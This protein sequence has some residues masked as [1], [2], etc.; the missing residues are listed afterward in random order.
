M[1]A[2]TMWDVILFDLD[3]TI[4]DPK[5]GITKSV[6]YALSHFGF[7]VED[8]DSLAYFIGPPLC[9]SFQSSFGMTESQAME[10]LS[11]YRER[12]SSIGWAE[13]VPYDSIEYC[14]E[15]LKDAGKYLMIATSKAQEFAE[16]I[17]TH[18]NLA[19]YFDQICG[20]P[21]NE[22]GQT[23][24]DVIRTAL[25]RAGISSLSKVVMVGDRCQDILGGQEVGIKTVGVLYGY[26][27][28]LE[29]ESCNADYI[30]EDIEEL[31]GLLLL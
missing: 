3:G 10:A 14:L 2:K 19:K 9:D 31:T 20:T 21:M 7:S 26:G 16:K 29:H 30:V 25:G 28:R 5:E 1:L 4:T 17:L 18:F 12:Y 15:Q 11:I 24:A 27:D 13:N 22:P 23:K 6:A 8:P